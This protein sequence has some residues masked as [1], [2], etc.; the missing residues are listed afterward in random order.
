MIKIEVLVDIKL[1]KRFN[2]SCLSD[3]YGS[4]VDGIALSVL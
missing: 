1:G 4:A 2:Y 3:K